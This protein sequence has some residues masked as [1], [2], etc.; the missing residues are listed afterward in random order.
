MSTVAQAFDRVKRLYFVPK[1]VRP[2]VQLDIP[3][4]IGYGQINSQPTTV[5]LMLEWLDAKKGQKVLDLGSGSGW[6]TA[7][8]GHIV[9]KNG[10]VY[11]VE[12]IPELVEFGRR[13][14]QD[15][16]IFNTEFFEADDKIVGLPQHAPF[17]RIL[18]SADGSKVPDELIDQ[19]KVGGKLVMP[20]KGIVQEIT[21]MPRG[22]LKSIEHPGFVFVP[23]V[24]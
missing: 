1:N 5:R 18:V 21:K 20:V 14:C 8:L 9:G 7:L 23:L 4:S 6:T 24:S 10:T 15:A 12:R 19:L 13:N 22:K 16:N 2:L 3:L 11:A 17:D